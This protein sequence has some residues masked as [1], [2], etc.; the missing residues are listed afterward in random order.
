M[1]DE[2]IIKIAI[3][4]IEI[5]SWG[6]TEQFLE[7]HDVV[8][9]DGVPKLGR[10]DKDKPGGMAIAYFPV[11]DEKFYF[12]IHIHSSLIGPPGIVG[13]GTECFNDISFQASSE[14]IDF[15]ELASLTNLKSTSGWHKGDLRRSGKATYKNALIRFTPNPEPDE[16]EDKLKKLLDFLEQDSTG[17]KK[18]IDFAEGHIQATIIFHNGNTMLGGPHIDKESIKRMAAFNLE[19]DFDLYAEGKFFKESH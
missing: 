18:L 8:R 16:F 3:Q 7:V 19:I 12:A 5:K 2:E 13:I 15:D 17:I 6:I 1:M 14:T 10:I 4:E 9:I 11:K